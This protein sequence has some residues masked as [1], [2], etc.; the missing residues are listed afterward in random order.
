MSITQIKSREKPS[1][2]ELPEG[3][4]L[5]EFCPAKCC[6]YIALPIDTPETWEDFDYIRWYLMHQDISVFVEDGEWYLMVHRRC[7]HL[8]PD[9]RC[10]IYLQRPQICR[11]Y[12]IDDCEYEDDTTYEK[13][14]ESDGQIWEYAEAVLGPEKIAVRPDTW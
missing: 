9:N 7:E 2:D 13:I 5:C 10:G 8:E 6:N 3:T 4:I 1:R 12:K 11:D 14:F